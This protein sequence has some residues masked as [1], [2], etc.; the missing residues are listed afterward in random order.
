MIASLSG[1]H[2]MPAEIPIFPLSGALL[3]PRGILPLN[4]FEPRYLAMVEDALASQHRLIGMIQPKGNREN[5][6]PSVF[7]IGCAGRITA[8]D[9]TD[10][11][12]YLITLTGISRF[13]VVE[14][15]SSNRGYRKVT[16]GWDRFSDDFR[17]TQGAQLD[18]DRLSAALAA[19]FDKNGIETD[20]Q[21]ISET[22]D[23]RLVTSL[24]MICPF[25]PTEKQALLECASFSQRADLMT[26]LIEMA[27]I[28][29]QADD[30]G[31]RH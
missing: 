28:G 10:D 27:V 6:T 22:P 21:A 23:E 26:S 4:I 5:E 7:D 30:H 8:M 3:L 17:P 13:N 15:V 31:Q 9:E 25:E 2:A 19:Y 14:E 11:G 20:W 18:R 16:A 24:C 1:P 12:R 29:G